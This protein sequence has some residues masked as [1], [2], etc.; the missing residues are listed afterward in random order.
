[1]FDK[2]YALDNHVRLITK[3]YGSIQ[4]V[5]KELAAHTIRCFCFAMKKVL[6]LLCHCK[7]FSVNICYKVCI[8]YTV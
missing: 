2:V 5:E 1:M 3:V 8:R 6:R 7:G 4:V